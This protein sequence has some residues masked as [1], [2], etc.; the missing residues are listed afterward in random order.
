MQFKNEWGFAKTSEVATQLT[1]RKTGR[2]LSWSQLR[3]RSDTDHNRRWRNIKAR[4]IRNTFSNRS[5]SNKTPSTQKQIIQN[6]NSISISSNSE[7]VLWIGSKWEFVVVTFLFVRSSFFSLVSWR[8]RWYYFRYPFT[9]YKTKYDLGHV[10]FL[11]GE[12]GWLGGIS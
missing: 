2:E 11:G 8:R 7:H 3:W 1:I 12:G 4:H 5:S 9:S 6:G 10:Q